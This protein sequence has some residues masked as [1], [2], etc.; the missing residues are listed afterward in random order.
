MIC[1]HFVHAINVECYSCVS[2]F[3]AQEDKPHNARLWQ[4]SRCRNAWNFKS[5]C[6]RY[7]LIIQEKH[8]SEL[9]GVLKDLCQAEQTIVKISQDSEWCK[10]LRFQSKKSI[11][12]FSHSSFPFSYFSWKYI[13]IV[14]G[15]IKIATSSM[16][17]YCSMALLES[18]SDTQKRILYLLEEVRV[19]FCLLS[20]GN[21][22][23]IK[24]RKKEGRIRS[25]VF[26]V[27]RDVTC[28]ISY[29]IQNTP[30]TYLPT[31]MTS[32]MPSWGF[33]K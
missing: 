11:H 21:V 6:S 29:C 9:N 1:A 17:S 22:S 28:S 5:E 23:K 8:S 14:F 15:L 12:S 25:I 20:K 13:G 2:C 4:A 27:R 31:L 19:R 24:E 7:E 33:Q 10:V 32:L 30:N 18:Y 26:M 3:L 16:L